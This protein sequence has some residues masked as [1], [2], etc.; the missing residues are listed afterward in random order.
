MGVGDQEEVS[1]GILGSLLLGYPGAA[2][3]SGA[4][5]EWGAR[6]DTPSIRRR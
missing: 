6:E 2:S 5:A 3:G 4:R 1:G